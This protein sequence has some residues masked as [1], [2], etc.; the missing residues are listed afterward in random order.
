LSYGSINEGYDLGEGCSE[1][2][3]LQR[4]FIVVQYHYALSIYYSTLA[5]RRHGTPNKH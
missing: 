3:D 1:G 4:R 5:R 2:V